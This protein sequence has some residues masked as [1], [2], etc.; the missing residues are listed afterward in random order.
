MP[1]WS[2]FWPPVGDEPGLARDLKERSTRAGIPGE[3]KG[4]DGGEIKDVKI[5]FSMT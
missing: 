5:N 2:W 1:G 3:G 4:R